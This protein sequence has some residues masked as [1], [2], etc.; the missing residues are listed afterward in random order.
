[1]K[2]NIDQE[3]APEEI[4]LDVQ[5][6]PEFDRAR[7]EGRLEKP[8]SRSAFTFLLFGGAFLFVV[9]AFQSL[10]LQVFQGKAY[11]A[12][13]EQN[14]LAKQVIFAARGIITDRNGIVL[15]DNQQQPD[16]SIRR[17]YPIPS[18]GQVIGYVSYPKKDSKGNYY[19]TSEQGLDGVEATYDR[20]LEGQNGELLIETDALG[21]VRSSGTIIPAKDGSTLK[22]SLDADLEQHLASALAQV[23]N[24]DGFV[25]GA[26][27]IMNVHTG[28]IVAMVSYPSYDP[29]VMSAGGPADVIAGY[30]TSARKVFLDRA[31][32]GLYAPGSVVKPIVASGVLTDG[33]ISPDTIIQDPGFISVKNPYDPTQSFIYKDW[34]ALGEVDIRKAIAWSSDVYFYTVGGGFGNQKGLGIDRLDYWYRIFG[35]GA[36]TG[37]GLPGERAG[38][39]PSPAWKEKTFGEQ[40]F[41]GDTYH[42]AIGQYGTQVTPIQMARATAAVANGGSLLTPTLLADQAPVS[43]S[44]P[45][46]QSALQVVREGMRQGVTSALATAINY[47]Y[48]SI[49]AKTGTAQVGAQNQFDNAWVEGFFP[50][51][52][53]QYAFAVVLERGP[54]GLGEEGV[55]VMQTLFDSLHTEN[56]PYAG[57]TAS[58]TLSLH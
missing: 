55:T 3:I 19:D 46:S 36:D 48:L 14:S 33:I 24:H 35:L 5:N 20:R 29:N 2:R 57:G 51:D 1:M 25:G 32:A 27:V 23:A 16:G 28:E 58:T 40:W 22:L 9:L 15:A 41:L 4:F 13:S 34:K 21:N 50:Y 43:S 37:V 52:N 26:G 53:P 18:A 12:R 7:F 56:S 47:P 42:T 10:N 49:A 30:N 17:V 8:L 39:I 31:V 45:V 38:N 54:V 44:L 6:E 11:A